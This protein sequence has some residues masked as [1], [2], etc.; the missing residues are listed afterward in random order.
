MKT[1]IVKID[2]NRMD[3][4]M[5]QEAGEVIRSGGLVAFPTETVY[6]LGGDAL[7]AESSGKIYAAKGRPSDN[8]LIVHIAEKENLYQIAAEVPEAAEKLMDRF[9]PGPLTM[10]F[11]KKECVPDETTGGLPTVAVRMPSDPAA[12]AFIRAAGGFV[13]APSANISGRPSTTKAEHVIDDLLG[14]IDMILDGGSAVI[15]LESSIVDM[16]ESRPVIL[17]PGAVT[18]EMLEQVLGY[19]EVDKTIIESDSAVKPKAPGMKYRHYAPRADMIIV[20]GDRKKVEKK[21][22]G[23]VREAH[24][25]GEK[26]GVLATDETAACYQADVVI[27]LGQ[28]WREEEISGRL[29]DALR[30]FDETDVSRI[31][32]ESFSD[33]GIGAAIMNRL[34]KAAGN[35]LIKV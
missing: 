31:Y 32:S 3:M 23:L 24:A 18:K 26:A 28:A 12:R 20:K 22:S 8:P 10:I 1:R 14:R 25:V 27:S 33:S 2:Y 21:I 19:V 29:F 30:K 5:I 9:W 7:N 13:S 35:K 15:G 11:K 16:S 34:L 4:E 6:G 17:R